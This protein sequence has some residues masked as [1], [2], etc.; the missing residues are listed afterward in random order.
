MSMGRPYDKEHHGFEDQPR[1]LGA[2]PDGHAVRAEWLSARPR[3]RADAREGP[4]R[5]RGPRRSGRR[6]R[7]SLPR[8]AQRGVARRGARRARRPRHLH[9]LL[10]PARRPALRQGRPHVA[11]REGPRGGA[12]AHPGR[13]GVRR[14]A[15]RA[16]HHLA[17]G[18]GLQLPVPDAVRREL[19][20]A[21]RRHRPGRAALRRARD[22]ALPRA[23]ELRAGDEDPHGQRRDD[24]AR[25]PQA[26]RPGR[27]QRP[28]QH[29]LA[30]PDH[31]RREPGRVRRAARRRGPARPPA[32]QLRLG[33]VRRR[34]HDRRHRV[35]GDARGG[36]RAAPRELRRQRRAARHGSLSVHRGPGRGGAPQRAAVALH[37]RGR[38]A[39]RRARNARLPGAQGRRRRLRARLRG[40]GGVTGSAFI[41][42]DV[43]TTAVK[44]LAV[45]PSGEVLARAQASYPLST[46]RPGWAEQDPEDWWRATQAALADLGVTPAAIGL[47]GQMH[48]L[49]ALDA[50]DE[51]IR[52]AILWNDG[53]TQRQCDA[54]E[55]TVGLDRLIALT[56]NR[57]LAGFTAPKLLWLRDEEPESF[58][59][60]R[61]ILLPK[62]YVRLRLTGEKATDVSDASGT[63]LFD[64]GA[65]AWS[66]PLLEL[67]ELDAAI[68][69]PALESPEVTGSYQGV[70][71][72]AGGG[73][74]GA[75]A[76]G[77]GV[78]VPGGPLSV[79]LGTS[80]VVFAALPGFAADR[81][82]RVHAFCHAV[83]GMWHAMGV[84]L[85]A[86][87]ALRW[88]HDV[89]GAAPYDELMAEA[90]AW[91][92]G[93]EGLTFLPYLA[94]ERT[95]HADP[96]ARGAFAGLSLRHDRGALVRA[97][98]EGVAF[99]LRDS[100]DLVQA[101]GAG[102]RLGRV[103]G[104]GARS[105]EWLR[106]VASVL[107]LPLE[108]VAVE[109]G[110]AYGAALLGG[111]AG[112]VWTD[113]AE[114]VS[115]CVR[116][117]GTVE[118]VPEWIEA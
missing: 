48:G 82:A 9:D 10:R 56:G 75:G 98:L 32:R 113:H 27:G 51:V 64:V 95:P 54:I 69:P 83:P 99:G 21:H 94:G 91:E 74:Q 44:A 55:E 17:R 76:V 22:Q 42:I 73:D 105:E 81:E 101:M 19:G 107:E 11:R 31:E 77:V 7:V 5:G 96:D 59:R 111:I 84:M 52:P 2:G 72:V 115:A 20:A 16:L 47:S 106:I 85:S 30:A 109:E 112:G 8:R 40:A 80:G 53:R 66:A 65:R 37:R 35:H 39:D 3:A 63:L 1:H 49:V 46:P 6:V 71:V 79:A 103:S 89:T 97:V 110:A 29:G 14:L 60:I 67:L 43:G 88:L 58:A 57:A 116:A 100:L 92:P 12:E 102:A 93:V 28:G 26:A 118:P 18:R 117:R 38:G 4:P 68:L 62:D 41:G 104:G 15:R 23:Q 24:A 34:Q 108:R 36:A 45:S 70:P 90:E 86:A 13:R 50:A 25:D 114:A 87:G 61:S 33:H 78:T